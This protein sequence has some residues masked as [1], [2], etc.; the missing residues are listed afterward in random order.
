M[1]GK[2]ELVALLERSAKVVEV[3][4]RLLERWSNDPAT[5]PG[6][7]AQID[8]V[9]R[10]IGVG[11]SCASR[12][13]KFVLNEA[14]SLSDAV[15]APGDQ[16]ISAV[17]QTVNS[18]AERLT[19]PGPRLSDEAFAN[20]MLLARNNSDQAA[21]NSE[22]IYSDCTGAPATAPLGLVAAPRELL[23]ALAPGAKPKKGGKG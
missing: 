19:W 11:L 3:E 6:R 16:H 8:F 20:A 22:S 2:N 21:E 18:I 14:R 23:N 17:A 12:R 13:T 4:L 10:Y 1:P 5:T 9:A 15:H 7:K